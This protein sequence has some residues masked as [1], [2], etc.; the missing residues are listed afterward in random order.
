MSR[1]AQGQAIAP[2]IVAQVA[3]GLRYAFTGNAP[4]WF[5]PFNPMPPAVSGEQAQQAG[6]AGRRYDYPVGANVNF[7]PRA[8]EAISFP[9][10]RAL[11][12]N[13]DVLRLVIETRKDQAC[14]LAWGIQPKDKTKKP[15][16]RCKAI[17]DFLAMP[18]QEHTWD[19]WLRM[20]LE[21]MYVIDAPTLYIRRTKG[22]QLFSLEPIDGA[23]IH[24]VIDATGRTP[25]DGP[26]YQQ[27]L[28][29]VPAVDY[30]LDELI[31]K[32][33]NI[34]T[35]KLYGYSPVEQIINTINIALRRQM[36]T[37]N[38]FTEGTVPDALAGV[39]L[40]WTPQ[41]IKEFQDYWDMLLQ[42]DMASRR[43]LK[44]VP[45][46]IAKN[47]HEVKAPPLKD[48][49]DEWLARVVCFTFSIEHTAFVSQVNRATAE[50]TR[51]QSLAEG[52]ASTKQWIKVLIDRIIL[53]CFGYTDL[54]FAWAPGKII[55]PAVQ[56]VV[57]SGYVTAK[58]LTDDEARAEIGKDPLTPEQRE[59]MSPP[60]PVMGGDEKDP[61]GADKEPPSPD[62]GKVHKRKKAHRQIDRDRSAVATNTKAFTDLMS[63]YLSGKKAGIIKQ[64][65]DLLSAEKLEKKEKGIDDIDIDFS[66]L[67]EDAKGILAAMAVDGGDEALAQFDVFDEETLKLVRQ[68]ATEWADDR[69]A[70]MVGMKWVDGE[71]VENP[72]A[73]WQITEGTREFLRSDVEA[74]LDEGWSTDE[75][76]SALEENYAFS[77]ERADM[78]ARTE[79]A[80]ADVE[81][82]RA[83]WDEMGVQQEEWSASP[84]CC[85]ACQELD[86]QIFD[87]GAAPFPQHPN[88][89]CALLPVIPDDE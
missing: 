81:G 7:Q 83:G 8:T 21:D 42:D 50:T 3:A 65:C 34:R 4:D 49:F 53:Q 24:R 45:G 51:E 85:D 43:K 70:E 89:E 37:L 44:F 25:M 73:E 79:I 30:T 66:D 68:Q 41:Q 76:S 75:L 23:T 72:D 36:M 33:R 19:E 58:I 20:L 13:Y 38:Y 32:P 86:G 31:Y 28:K 14:S 47:F 17:E 57:L 77:E 59:T 27:I 6:V 16:D 26:A 64:C 67:P 22:G 5:G 39:P 18:D 62:A 54:E 63:G 74:A 87:L 10:L 12:E 55:D 15:D 29:G 35:H 11:A 40:D 78:I 88:D 84:G 80:R 48:L 56:Q 60:P 9:T 61:D 52:L 82:T 69:A 71:L 46:E 2:G 1:N